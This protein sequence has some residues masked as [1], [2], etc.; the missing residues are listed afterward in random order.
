MNDAMESRSPSAAAA[1]PA[2]P[3]ADPAHLRG[4]V[5]VALAGA[6]W[7][8]GGVLV[9][10]IEAASAWQ[11]IFYRSLA[12][13]LTLVLIV[14]IRHRGRLIAAFADVGCNGL[15]AGACLSGGFMGFILAL[16]H[17]TVANVVF[18]LGAPRSL[19]PSSAGGGSANRCDPPPGSP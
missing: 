2:L 7:S 10:W 17:T 15:L 6:F 3:R 1:P 14:A 11:I 13:T 4:V 19:P 18:M 12:L 5:L 16:S 8:L 9:R